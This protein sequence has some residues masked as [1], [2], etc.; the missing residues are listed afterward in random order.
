M[1]SFP[2]DLQVEIRCPGRSSFVDKI[3]AAYATCGAAGNGRD[4]AQADRRPDQL[5]H[6]GQLPRLPAA[7][8]QGRRR[9]DGHR[10][11]LLQ[12]PRRLVRGC[13][14]KIDLQPG[15][16][17][18]NGYAA[19]DFVRFRH[20]D[21]D[22]YRNARQQLF[23][24]AFK[25]Q[26]EASFSL[27]KLPQVIKVVTSQ[28]RGRPG[29]RRGRQPEDGARATRPSPTRC[30]PA[31]SSSRGSTASRA[32]PTSTTAPENIERAV[33]EFGN[34][35]VESPR[36]ATAVALGE[37]LKQKVPPPR[38]TSVLVLNGNGVEGSASTASYLLGQRGYRMLAP[39][40]RAA[41]ERADATTSSARR[42][43]ST[44]GSREPSR[45]R[46]SSRTCSARPTSRGSRRRSARSATTR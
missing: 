28:R 44:R 29:R 21:S 1:L 9:L 39:A 43:T 45:R 12:R 6:H 36:K 38:A 46:E 19:L 24:R 23:V 31:T 33:R 10:P 37:K 22:L 27:L 11:P 2:R 13:Y 18:L 26:I 35:D 14:A 17:R 5:H 4:R 8:R 3:N 42:S 25:D 20:T 7:R 16:Q 15:Y 41:G 34:P 32:S 30:R 40:E